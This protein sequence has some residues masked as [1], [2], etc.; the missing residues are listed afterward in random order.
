MLDLHKDYKNLLGGLIKIKYTR[1]YG[2]HYLN[3]CNSVCP[4]PDISGAGHLTNVQLAARAD[5][6]KL[7]FASRF[8][9]RDTLLK[10]DI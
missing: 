9:L 1:I 3:R 4:I 2:N 10:R 7:A 6:Q 5:E 8:K